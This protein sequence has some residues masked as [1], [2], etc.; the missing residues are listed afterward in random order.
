MS[1]SC[2]VLAGGKS[3]RLGRNKLTEVIGQM[4]LIETVVT[5]LSE[6][7]TPIIV[8][9]ASDSV[10]PHLS[11]YT[12]TKIVQDI[13]PE[14]GTLGGIYT[15]LYESG[16][17]HNMVVACDMPF[18]NLNLLS[19]MAGEAPDYDVVVPRTTDGVLEPLHAIYSKHCMEPIEFLIK[20]GRLSV[21]ELYPMVKVKYLE[22]STINLLDPENLSFFNINT[23][24]D[25]VKG[26][27]LADQN[28]DISHDKC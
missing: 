4:S 12:A 16:T 10:I 23:E 27:Q 24:S 18:I 20:Q 13:F 2:I 26:R 25:L 21:L 5:R 1:V 28:K 11:Q 9:T 22:A 8:V 3:K 19:Y 6:L 14:K 7:K 17:Y 15:G